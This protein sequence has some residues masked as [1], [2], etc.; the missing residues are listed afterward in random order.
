MPMH[1]ENYQEAEKGVKLAD[2]EPKIHVLVD[3]FNTSV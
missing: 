2:S 1:E 3:L